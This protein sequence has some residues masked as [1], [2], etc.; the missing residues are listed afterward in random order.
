M[1][2]S[3]GICFFKSFMCLDPLEIQQI[4]QQCKNICL[5][6]PFAANC[7][8]ILRDAES[9]TVLTK[10]GSLWQCHVLPGWWQTKFLVLNK[11]HRTTE[12]TSTRGGSLRGR[13]FLGSRFDCKLK[14]DLCPS[15]PVQTGTYLILTGMIHPTTEIHFKSSSDLK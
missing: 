3:L 1:Q 14:N 10:A 4:T 11:H 13:H 15:S 9:P 8:V 12:Q 5:F 2:S 7:W 6:L